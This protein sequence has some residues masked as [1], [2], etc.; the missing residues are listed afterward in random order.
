MSAV[1]FLR[2]RRLYKWWLRPL[3]SIAARPQRLVQASALYADALRHG[4]FLASCPRAGTNFLYA[5]LSAADDA[6]RRDG[7]PEYRYEK[8]SHSNRG[9]WVF[10]REN[11]IPNNLPHFQQGLLNGEFNPLSERFFVLSHY[12]AVRSESLF[13][14][15]WMRPV[16]VVR[17]PFRAARSLFGWHYEEN[18][19]AAHRVFLEN[20]VFQIIRFFNY[21]GP[22]VR[23]R[24]GEDLCLI[25]YEDL[26]DDPVQCLSSIAKLWN[27][28]YPSRVLEAAAD[29]CERQTMLDKIPKHERKE[30]KRVSIDRVDFPNKVS[31]AYRVTI[32]ENLDDDFGYDI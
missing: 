7:T 15:A 17:H 18:T 22:R 26:A 27:F 2:R 20:E 3:A 21:W 24:A 30:N 23:R 16:V 29:A 12:P 25:R 4:R 8:Q 5:L 6:C 14:P 11:R 28:D 9:R 10:E 31:E 32:R 19:E 13:S 1:D